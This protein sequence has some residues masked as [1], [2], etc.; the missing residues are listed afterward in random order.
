MTGQGVSGRLMSVPRVTMRGRARAEGVVLSRPSPA[1]QTRVQLS[2][3]GIAAVTAAAGQA[4]G[5]PTTGARLL[6]FTN[7]AVVLLPAAGAVL[8]IAGSNE[9]RARVPLVV[10][11]ARWLAAL[12]LPA[13]RLHPGAPNPLEIDGHLVT[14]WEAVAATGAV[15]TA[16]GLAGILR[17]LHA[18]NAPPPRELPEWNIVAVI[19]RR[20][21]EADGVSDADLAFLREELAAVEGMISCAR[22]RRAF[23]PARRRARGRV[24]GQ[25]HR[26]GERA[27]DLRLRRCERGPAGVGP[28]AGGRRGPALRLRR[29]PAGGVRGRV[30][31]RRHGVARLPR[32]ATSSESSSS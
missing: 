17:E 20:L 2:T 15:A 23:G 19:G 24:P 28:R 16:G 9:V 4:T 22:G 1:T 5:L 32:V 7:N 10:V 12:G 30:R 27:R 3:D 11:A 29:G 8:R 18:V 26:L 25:C 21:G 13:V 6:K 14:V 31:R